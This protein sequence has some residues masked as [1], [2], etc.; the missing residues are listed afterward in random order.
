MTEEDEFD[1]LLGHKRFAVGLFN[2]TWE[3]MDKKD[4]T[5]AEDDT[6]IHSAHASRFHWGEVVAAGV[7][8]TGPENLER[9]DWQISRV[10]TVLGKAEPAIYHAERCLAICE[11]N[12]IGDWDIAFAYE[13]LARA[14]AVAGNTAEA[15]KYIRL[16]K[17]AGER[18][19]EKG[20]MDYFLSELETVPGYK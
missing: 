19:K 5:R 16:G 2:K 4:R 11:E 18:I 13:A 17:E 3:L 14:H 10:Y 8:N 15:D 1:E 20:D 9:G 6:M 7:P 12:N